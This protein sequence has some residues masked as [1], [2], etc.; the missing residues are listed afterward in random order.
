[1]NKYTYLILRLS[2]GT[3]MFGHGLVRMPKLE[4]FSAWMIAQFENSILPKALVVP[5]SYVLPF[6]E[7][8]TGILLLLG[9]FTRQAIFLGSAVMICLLFGTT[10]IENWE[11]IP[12]QLIHLAF[13]AVLLQFVDNNHL[14]L[15]KMAIRK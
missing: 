6:A 5:F 10:I 15:D 9:L 13:F 14:A 2:I 12:T 8:I 3:S 4:G 11:A 1:M 7:L